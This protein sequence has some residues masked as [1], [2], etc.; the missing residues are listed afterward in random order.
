MEQLLSKQQQTVSHHTTLV[1]QTK[2][3]AP[4]KLRKPMASQSSFSFT[5]TN[6]RNGSPDGN[7]EGQKTWFDYAGK[8]AQ[9]NGTWGALGTNYNPLFIARVLPDGSSW[10]NSFIRNQ[11]GQPTKV[12]GTYGSGGSLATRTNT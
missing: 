7:V 6:L 8:V 9:P 5:A 4:W 1:A 3:I 10:F 12:I 11:W 2:S